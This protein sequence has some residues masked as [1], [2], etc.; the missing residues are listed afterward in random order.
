[1]GRAGV[2]AELPNDGT[3]ASGGTWRR[4]SRFR[5]IGPMY[6]VGSVLNFSFAAKL[7]ANDGDL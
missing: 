6:P 3:P 1:V 7:R 5:V 4:S 2:L